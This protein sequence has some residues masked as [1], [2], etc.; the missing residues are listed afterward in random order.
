MKNSIL[1][2]LC[3]P[4]FLLSMDKHELGNITEDKELNYDIAEGNSTGFKLRLQKYPQET[5]TPHNIKVIK[6]KIKK[7]H[8]RKI[9]ASPRYQIPTWYPV[10]TTIKIGIFA[11]LFGCTLKFAENFYSF[12]ARV[13]KYAIPLI[14]G[15]AL[16]TAVPSIGMKIYVEADSKRFDNE[17]ASYYSRKDLLA[18]IKQYEKNK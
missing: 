17:L 3:A 8:T 14:F 9:P 2:F 7:A 11:F 18:L 15:T 13:D 6:Q 16:L 5:F 10:D 4:L 12:P 1:L